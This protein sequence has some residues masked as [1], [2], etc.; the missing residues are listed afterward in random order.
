M[1]IFLAFLFGVLL[2]SSSYSQ[3]I[4]IADNNPGAPAGSH[5]YSTLQAAINAAVAGD[6]I[7]VI[8]SATSYDATTTI[9]IVKDSISIYGIGFKP[10]KDGPQI[11]TIFALRISG[12]NIRISGLKITNSTYVGYDLGS[13]SG[14]TIENC[15]L[16]YITSINNASITVNNVL[17]RGCYVNRS[18]NYSNLAIYFS[19][20]INQSVITNCIIG[21]YDANTTVNYPKLEAYNGTIIKN[22]IFYGDGRTTK[23]SFANL[24]N[25][26]VSNNIFFGSSPKSNSINFY[27]NVFNNNVTVASGDNAMPPLGIGGTNTGSGNFT[28]ITDTASVF[29]DPNIVVGVVAGAEWDYTWMPNV[30]HPSL[31]AGGT[32]GTDVGVG[33]S[34]IPF[35]TTGTTLPLI[36]KLI[37]PE[38]IKQGDNLNTSIEAQ[39]Y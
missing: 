38:V 27:N 13:Y 1:K 6:I 4:L 7:H 32:D 17:V 11:A 10:D 15:D 36:Q 31:I 39:G 28:T 2:I 37:V 19:P 35:S 5:I 8:P 20:Q 24:I 21:G 16:A 33:G 22:C 23:P 26:T 18:T 34:T 29:S 14:I 9:F 3:N 12:S 25:C 30:A